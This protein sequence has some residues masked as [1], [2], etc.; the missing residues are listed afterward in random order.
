MRPMGAPAPLLLA[1]LAIITTMTMV[2]MVE[3]PNVIRLQMKEMTAV[4]LG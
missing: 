4:G 1:M 2:R 3:I